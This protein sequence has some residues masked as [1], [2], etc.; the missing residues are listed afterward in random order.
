[1]IKRYRVGVPKDPATCPAGIYVIGLK[2]IDPTWYHPTGG[3]IPPNHPDNALGTRWMN[4]FQ[5]G[6]KTSLGIHGN[7][8][9]ETVGTNASLGCIRMYNAD[10]EELFMIARQ[11]SEVEVVY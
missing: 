1:M 6:I 7:N 8:D 5:D 9:P 11:G 2:A 3:V 4:L 10:V